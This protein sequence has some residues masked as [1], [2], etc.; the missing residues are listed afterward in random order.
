MLAR[1]CRIVAVVAAISVTGIFAA[2]CATRELPSEREASFAP[3]DFCRDVI[4]TLATGDKAGAERVFKNATS[5]A[6]DIEGLKA[7]IDK[8]VDAIFGVIVLRTNGQPLG[9]A[10]T[11]VTPTPQGHVSTIERWQ[12]RNNVN[13]YFGCSVRDQPI[14]GLSRVHIQV[15]DTARSARR[16]MDDFHR[17]GQRMLGGIDV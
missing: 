6:V 1:C 10:E 3:Q 12:S 5:P 17:A 11:L 7:E 16:S 9:Y 13:I 15:S 2:G 14:A 8:T 4:Q